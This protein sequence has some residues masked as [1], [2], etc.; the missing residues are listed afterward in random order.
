MNFGRDS[1]REKKF[2]HFNDRRRRPTI[3]G[4]SDGGQVVAG[5][6][7][8]AAVDG[9]ILHRSIWLYYGGPICRCVFGH[10][11]LGFGV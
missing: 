10:T 7:E 9:G 11:D 1:T 4:G 6:G 5:A 8:S 2:N 3:G